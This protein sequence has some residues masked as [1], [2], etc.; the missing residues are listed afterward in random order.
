ME[1]DGVKEGADEEGERV[2][3]GE[4]LHSL[5]LLPW[6]GLGQELSG[7]EMDKKRQEKEKTSSCL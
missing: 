4:P 7:L 2:E 1:G 5:V 6:G 3:V